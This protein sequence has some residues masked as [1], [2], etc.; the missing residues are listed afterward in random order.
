MPPKGIP[1]YRPPFMG[2]H[3]MV[4][5]GHWLASVAGLRILQEGGNAIDAGVASGIALNV[6]LPNQTSFAGVAPTVLYRADAD[7][8]V[9]I[10]GLGRWPRAADLD[11]YRKRYGGDMP[12]GI[13]RSVVPAARDA[14]LTA[15]E[16]YGTM[17][18]EQVVAPSVELAEEGFPVSSYTA[19]TLEA[20]KAYIEGFP[21]SAEI[22]MPNGQCLR[23]GQVLLQADLAR[24]FRQMVEVEQANTHKGRAGAIRA[25]RDFFYK[26]EVA[27]K[28]G[29][30]SQQQDG[31]LTTDDFAEFNVKVENPEVG[32][33]KEYT[34]YTCGPWCQGPSL[35]QVLHIIEGFD[36]RGMGHN[37][38]QYVHTLIEAVKLAFA[39]RHQDYGDPDHVDVPMEGLLSKEYAAERRSAIDPGRACPEMPPAGVPWP[40]KGDGRWPA[41][42]GV[43]RAGSP[44]TDTSYTCVVDQWGNAF[45]AT[46]SDGVAATPIVPG[47]G[48]IISDRGR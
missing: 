42:Q 38:A 2:T 18:F 35:I 1:S 26:G 34:V 4:S 43:S 27:E 47:L 32:S 22:F 48:L 24:L 13:P 15:L 46:P 41:A 19:K 36:L 40:L 29:G 12:A 6:T 44:E 25:A 17:S 3:H 21:S 14:W 33:Y 10:S 11:G 28:M 16:I 45:S 30:F 37:S 8:V 39:D 31:L 5:S 9:T 23:P 20:A 7:E